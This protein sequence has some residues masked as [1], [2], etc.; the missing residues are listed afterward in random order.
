MSILII[1]IVDID[2]E[3]ATVTADL[4]FNN[5][6]RLEG[7]SSLVKLED[8]ILFNNRI[9]LIDNIDSLTRLQCLSIGNNSISE[10]ESVCVIPIDFISFVCLKFLPCTHCMKTVAPTP[11]GTGGTCPPLLQ[12]A[13]HG[14]H[15]ELKNSKQ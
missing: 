10:L 12:M 14:G 5:I 7:L 15:C 2:T 3:V 13:G 9:E 4:S 1:I 11:W 6:E 8:L